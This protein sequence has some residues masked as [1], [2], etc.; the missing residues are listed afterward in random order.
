M[1]GNTPYLAGCANIVSTPPPVNNERASVD[2]ASEPPTE[3]ARSIASEIRAAGPM[4]F[5]A[6]MQRALYDPGRGYYARDRTPWSEGA[7]FVTAPQV[8]AA[9]GVAVARMA[10]ECDAAL[11][12]PE[13]FDLVEIG[14]GD[15]ALL[16][17]V[18][19]ALRRDSPDLYDRLRVTGVEQ[20]GASRRRQQQWL[21]PH[22]E[23]LRIVEDL[24]ELP[25]RLTGLQF[26]N[27]LLD[28]LPVHRIVWRDDRLYELFVDWRRGG[29]VERAGEPSTT[30]LIDYLSDN[31]IVLE[32]GQVAEICLAVQHWIETL[33]QRLERGY[34]L[35]VDYGAE[36]K[37]L[38]GPG[39]ARGS[40]VCQYRYDLSESPY[41][42]VGEQD[43]TAHVD[44]GNLRRCGGA[45]G[46]RFGGIVGLAAFLLGFGA[47]QELPAVRPGE[48]SDAVRA[49][50]GL[51]HLLFT[52]IGAA[53]RAM[54]QSK[55]APSIPFGLERLA[56]ASEDPCAP[57]HA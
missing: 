20:G 30:A 28:A 42:R 26:S 52:E 32:E 49:R 1:R 35:T 7:D 25:T 17:D 11:G 12:S 27:E 48:G 45:V 5:R 10:S 31:E 44:F 38:Y 50:L 34:V 56:P 29:F 57:P 16:A 41:V 13:R 46:L 54:L 40:L 19:D 37:A 53:H 22:A 43:I 51:R 55:H 2:D 47:A 8:D 15:G 9:F 14:G 4:T 23:R 6:F 33:A 3:L 36:T 21:A 39:R 24:D 18:C